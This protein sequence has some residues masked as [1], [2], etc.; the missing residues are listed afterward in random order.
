MHLKCTNSCG[1]C[2]VDENPKCEFW[3]SIGE[4]ENNQSMF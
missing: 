2:C 3:A 1:G 4:C